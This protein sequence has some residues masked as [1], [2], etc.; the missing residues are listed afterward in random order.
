MK[1]SHFGQ[2]QT[3]TGNPFRRQRGG[4]VESSLT[5]DN[6]WPP[7]STDMLTDRKPLEPRCYHGHPARVIWY[8]PTC[9][10]NYS[11]PV[12]EGDNEPTEQPD[13]VRGGQR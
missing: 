4:A 5:V 8:C 6:T 11:P 9:E 13:D 12:A 7:V 2:G 1:S 3:P 10:R